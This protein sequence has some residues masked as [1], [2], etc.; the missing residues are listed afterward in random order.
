MRIGIRDGDF[1][2]DSMDWYKGKTPE[3][4][5]FPIKYENIFPPIH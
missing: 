2:K 1:Y 3:T 5:D 4:I